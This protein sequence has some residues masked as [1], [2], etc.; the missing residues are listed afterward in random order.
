[1]KLRLTLALL[2]DEGSTVRAFGSVDVT[3]RRPPDDPEGDYVAEQIGFMGDVVKRTDLGVVPKAGLTGWSLAA[4]ALRVLRMNESQD[5]QSSALVACFKAAVEMRDALDRDAPGPLN[6]AARKFD[7][8][9]DRLVDS[10]K[11]K[12]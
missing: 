10:L 9:C 5:A 7:A 2:S 3:N 6:A 11:K 4:Q 12:P 1:V 8:A